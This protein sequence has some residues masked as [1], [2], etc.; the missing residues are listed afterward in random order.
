MHGRL[1]EFVFRVAVW[2]CT[3]IA[4][5]CLGLDDLADY[6]EFTTQ[7]R[8]NFPTAEISETLISSV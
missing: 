7:C 4:L 2:L 1:T 8:G 3:E 6:G 5:T